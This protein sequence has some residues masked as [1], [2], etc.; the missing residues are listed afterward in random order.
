[1]RSRPRA[2]GPST[3]RT[4]EREWCR[5][6]TTSGAP[7]RLWPADYQ[8]PIEIATRSGLFGPGD[9]PDPGTELGGTNPGKVRKWAMDNFQI[10]P[11]MEILIWASGWYLAYRYWP[12]SYHTHRFEGTLFF[13]KATTASERAAQECAVVMFK[14]FALQDAGT[15]V[16]T[17]RAL[18]SRAARDDFPL[19]DQELLVRHFHRS[20][21]DWVEEYERKNTWSLATEP[22]RYERR[23]ASDMTELQALYDVGFPRIEEALGYCDKFP[24]DA[25]PDRARRLLELVHS[26]IMVWM[27]VEIW[28]Q[29]RVVD[30]ADAEIHRV[31]EP[32]P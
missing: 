8:Y 12:T 28:H 21:A 1:M 6:S 16:G 3:T 31:A 11:N 10:F 20:I 19:G 5:T 27:C 32:L 18:E 2:A 30:G 23:R 15:L 4:W 22:E 29:P 17:Q 7:R 9:E 25:L 26:I 14:E 13:P 24:L